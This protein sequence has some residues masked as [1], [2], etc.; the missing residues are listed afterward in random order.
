MRL[1]EVREEVV[2][3]C[4]TQVSTAATQKVLTSDDPIFSRAQPYA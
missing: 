1:E 2:T 3:P 4:G